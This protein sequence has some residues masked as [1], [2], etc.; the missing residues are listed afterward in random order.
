MRVVPYEAAHAPAWDGFVATARNGTF[1][2][3]RAF[4]DYH[5]ARFTDASVLVL[6]E[7][8]EVLAVL[9]ANRDG[10]RVISHGGL[11]YAGLLLS[12]R[13][14]QAQCL[15][16]MEAILQHYRGLSVGRLLYKPVPHIFHTRP[17]ED[18]LYALFRLGAT[19]VRRDASTA[20]SLRDPYEF[21]KGRKWSVNKGRKAGLVLRRQD[22]PSRFHALLSQVLARHGAS[23][24]HSLEELRLLM[25][26]FP[27]AIVLHEAELPA[28]QQGE[29]QAAVLVFDFGHVVHTQY[30]AASDAGRETGALDFLVAALMT[31]IYADRRHFS[32][33]ISTEQAGQVLNEG[34][35]AQKE[36]FGG[37]TVT[38]DFYELIL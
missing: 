12:G 24:V 6:G 15:Q 33:G 19:L 1:L 26:R 11:T 8:D 34:L 29:L 35:I 36:G 5:A 16:I 38:H 2:H 21:T 37:R 17:A 32:F 30:M 18:D 3:Q 25:S 22:D 10:D 20:V 23:P 9:P 14:G 4:M 7:K 28:E 13:V 31:D 27:A